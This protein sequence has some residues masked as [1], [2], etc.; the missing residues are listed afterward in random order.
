MITGNFG[1][2]LPITAGRGETTHLDGEIV[3]WWSDEDPD[4]YEMG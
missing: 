1:L 4:T 2:S 3:G